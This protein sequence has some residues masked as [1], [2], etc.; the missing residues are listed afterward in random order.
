MKEKELYF[1]VSELHGMDK[2]GEDQ[3]CGAKA[4]DL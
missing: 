2:G 3:L 1:L 4:L